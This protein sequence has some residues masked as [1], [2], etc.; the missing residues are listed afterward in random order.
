MSTYIDEND[1]PV[2]LAY[3]ETTGLCEPVRVDPTLGYIEVYVVPVDSN[4]PNT[5]NNAKIDENENS[6]LLGYNEST[7]LVEAV[8]CG[9]NGELLL[10]S[11]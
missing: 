2:W 6:T 4:T 5:L 11:V 8:R 9:S 3:N 1:K 10:I 7:G